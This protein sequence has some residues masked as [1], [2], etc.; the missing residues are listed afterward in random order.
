[1][2]KI[3]GILGGM[4][5][6]ATAYFYS[7]LIKHTRAAKDQEHIP[8]VI[9]SDPRV[10][11]RTAAILRG[12]PSPL[13]RLAAGARGLRRAGANFLVI[14]C[15]T[16]HYYLDELKK[17]CPIPVVSLLQETERF[18]KRSRPRLRCVGLLASSG[19]IRSGLFQKAMARVGV[20]V[21]VPSESE[22]KKVRE[23]IYGR[24]GIKA[25]FTSGKSKTLL[26]GV[27][28]H[29][30]RLGAQA[31]MAGCTEVPLALKPE[32]LPAPIL[33]PMDIAARSCILRAGFKLRG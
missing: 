21:L 25:G 26:R 6:E 1:V 11:D 10:P 12:G 15:L 4:G 29:L 17:A 3:I 22:Q 30:I 2:K 7:L 31:I 23:A 24:Q 20:Q 19:T 28:S 33:D 8:A 27:A 14:P 13:H 32:D 18:L 5:P 9:W 16:A